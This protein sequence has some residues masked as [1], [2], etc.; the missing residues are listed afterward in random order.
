[1]GTFFALGGGLKRTDTGYD[2]SCL[3][4]ILSSIRLN[5]RAQPFSIYYNTHFPTCQA[6]V[7]RSKN[8]LWLLPFPFLMLLLLLLLFLLLFL[9][10]FLLLFLLLVL[11]LPPRTSSPVLQASFLASRSPSFLARLCYTATL[12]Q[13]SQ[14]LPGRLANI[15]EA[16]RREIYA[17]SQAL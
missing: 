3:A 10:L 6:M 11:L 7:S 17:N 13:A 14:L 8:I 5:R 15:A 9:I 2:A 16:P 4:S 1:M 12:T